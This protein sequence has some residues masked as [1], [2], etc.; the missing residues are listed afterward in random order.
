M[1]IA[2]VKYEKN[3]DDVPGSVTVIVVKWSTAARCPDD[4]VK[5]IWIKMGIRYVPTYVDFIEG[6]KPLGGSDI[7]SQIA[8][9]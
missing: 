2:P 8:H 1:L 9:D 7:V 5:H 4:L 6:S 3:R